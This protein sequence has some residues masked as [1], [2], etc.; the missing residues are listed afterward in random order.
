AEAIREYRGDPPPRI[1]FT[2]SAEVYGRRTTDEF[3]LREHLELRPATPY[4][5]SKAAAEGI[6]LAHARSFGLDVVVA[7]AFNHIG[8]GQSE[9]FVVASLAA[10]LARVAAGTA[11]YVL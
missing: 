8:P 4:G 3:P 10:Q 6:L 7:R 2:S 9:R 1:V 11:P 5:A